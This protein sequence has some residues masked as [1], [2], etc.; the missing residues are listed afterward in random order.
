MIPTDAHSPSLSLCPVRGTVSQEKKYKSVIQAPD[1]ISCVT[2]TGSPLCQSRVVLSPPSSP[3]PCDSLLG[4]AAAPG[5]KSQRQSSSA[6]PFPTPP[7]VSYTCQ[8]SHT[9]PALLG[10]HPMSGQVWPHGME[11]I[12]SKLSHRC[13]NQ[14]ELPP[15]YILGGSHSRLP[16]SQHGHSYL[17]YP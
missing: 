14:G 10:C 3:K 5:F 2:A 6:A 15:S 1:S 11:P 4:M 13:C 9:H 7:T 12:F 17:T 16:G 8:L